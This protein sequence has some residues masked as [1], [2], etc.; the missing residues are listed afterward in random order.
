MTVTETIEALP[1]L[2]TG[3]LALMGS[4]GPA[5]IG[6]AGTAAA[7]GLRRALP[8]VAGSAVGTIA[9][10]ALLI[11]GAGALPSPQ[12]RPWGV[13]LGSVLIVLAVAY[14]LWLSW[15]I[16]T[17]PPP[18][19]VDGHARGPRFVA[20]FLLGVSNPKAYLALGALVGGHGLAGAGPLTAA[21][22]LGV[23][24]SL[25]A[26]VHVVWAALGATAARALQRPAVARI[27]NVGL[28]LLLAV[29]ALPLLADA[30]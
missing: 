2:V 4:P 11:V 28:A 19:A 23:L 17:A 13:D 26:T 1:S 25:V 24:A 8:Y 30:V 5:T 16:A 22:A 21:V 29:S 14:L 7:F 6:A 12:F 10:L 18:D 27:V 3:A 20:G 15:R 9:V